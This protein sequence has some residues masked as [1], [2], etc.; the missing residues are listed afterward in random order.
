MARV[1]DRPS[2]SHCLLH[3]A[4]RAAREWGPGRRPTNYGRVRQAPRGEAGLSRPFGKSQDEDDEDDP[5]DRPDDCLART[6]T[7]ARSDHGAGHDTDRQCAVDDVEKI[8]RDMVGDRH[9][10]RGGGSAVREK[11]SAFFRRA[12]AQRRSCFR[13]RRPDPLDR[14]DSVSRSARSCQEAGASVPGGPSRWPGRSIYSPPARRSLWSP[15]RQISLV[16]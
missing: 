13:D 7:A 10:P 6:R 9:A 15:S 14:P 4:D 3:K 1:P 5:G 11:R 16:T 8:M 2:L 12:E